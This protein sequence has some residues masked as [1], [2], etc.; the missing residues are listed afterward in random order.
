M[1]IKNI[2]NI[3][4]DIKADYTEDYTLYDI[5]KTAKDYYLTN[6]L[7]KKHPDFCGFLELSAETYCM[8]DRAFALVREGIV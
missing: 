6:E 1:K 8:S 2:S 5:Y 4:K 3:L 7:D